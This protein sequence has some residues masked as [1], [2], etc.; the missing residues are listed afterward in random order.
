[1]RDLSR[2]SAIRSITG[3]CLSR[4]LDKNNALG[5]SFV[6]ANGHTLEERDRDSVRILKL[7]ASLVYLLSI[8]GLSYLVLLGV[9]YG[10]FHGHLR[11]WLLLLYLFGY[12]IFCLFSCYARVRHRTLV[13]WGILFHLPLAIMLMLS[14][15]D[16][17][18]ESII[19]P[20]GYILL[21]TLV[22]VV[23][24]RTNDTA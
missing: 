22:C 12:L 9:G 3:L 21:W 14:V 23:R 5:I 4:R 16:Y 1:M 13:I 6:I 10:G 15:F 19:L 24:I 20:L 11:E 2:S 18:L 17:H 7:L 8:L